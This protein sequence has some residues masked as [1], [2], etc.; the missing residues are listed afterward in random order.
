[1]DEP[2]RVRPAERRLVEW[3]AQ[4]SVG[5]PFPEPWCDAHDP[6]ESILRTLVQLGVIERPAPD[7]APASVAREASARARLWLE[8]N[9]L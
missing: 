2:G 1:M 8:R 3:V 6:L 7:A 9:P 4:A 5:D